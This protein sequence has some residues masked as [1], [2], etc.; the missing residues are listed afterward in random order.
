[1]KNESANDLNP[2]IVIEA[3]DRFDRQTRI[4]KTDSSQSLGCWCWRA[5][6]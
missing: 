2:K 5:R 3:D 4:I 1:M 6:K